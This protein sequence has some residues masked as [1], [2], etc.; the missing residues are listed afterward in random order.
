MEDT[1]IASVLKEID[2]FATITYDYGYNA[3]QIGFVSGDYIYLPMDFDD[4]D[5]F[6]ESIYSD[7]RDDKKAITLRGVAIRALDEYAIPT[8]YFKKMIADI[9]SL[10]IS[11]LS[12]GLEE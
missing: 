1:E 10:D 5:N 3:A 8:D 4:Y 7:L 2:E 6:L 9:R 12:Y 11:A